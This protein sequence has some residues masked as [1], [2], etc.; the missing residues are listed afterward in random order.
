[1][2]IQTKDGILLRGIP[3]GTPDDE[4]KARIAK[5]RAERSVPPTEKFVPSGEKDP[6]IGEMIAGNPVTRFALGA[7]SPV[8]GAAQLGA[9]IQD[10]IY[11]LLGIPFQPGK[12]INEHLAQLERMKQGGRAITG[13]SGFDPVETAGAVVSPPFLA[14]AKAVQPAATLAGKVAQGTGFGVAGA[15]TAPVTGEG[16]YETQ[17]AVQTATGAAVG[18]ALPAALAAGGAVGKAGYRALIEPWMQPAAIK[19]RAFLEAAGDKADE[20]IALLRQ[21]REI[22]P[23]SRP[24][25]GEA[26]APAG[27]AE[28]AALQKSAEQAAPS[29]YLAR[30]D[31]QNAARL[32]AV[33]DVGKDKQ[34]LDTAIAVRSGK[35]QK[36]YGIVADDVVTPDQTFN[37]ILSRPSM[38]KAMDKAKALTAEQGGTW[39]EDLAQ[40]ATVRQ[41]QNVKMALDDMLKNPEQFGL[42]A[43]EA[44]AISATRIQFVQWLN[45][46]SPG[47]QYARDKFAAQSKPINQMEVGQELERRLVPALSEDAKQKASTYAAALQN[48]PQTIKKATGEPRYRDLSEVLTPD[49]LAKVNSVRDDLA[50]GARFEDMAKRGAGTPSAQEVATASMEGGTGGKLPNTLNPVVT[51]ANRIFSRLEGKI[52]KK[53][54]AE[55]AADML[56]PVKVGDSLAR[57]QMREKRNKMIAERIQG[58]INLGAAGSANQQ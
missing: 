40:G 55:I 28:F 50:R 4:I 22:V 16:D 10:P 58:Y 11:R 44:K 38:A 56:D 15:L 25:A 5:I 2:D 48:A 53:L 35:A 3:D 23:G 8:L 14:A 37:T 19:G 7:A 12:G 52:N 49:Q 31:E 13:D 41:M 54:A 20:I 26:A 29:K 43:S 34:A 18:A 47:W 36:N 6:P 27:R 17:K 9:N 57:A 1:M 45:K 42:G 51:W 30:A 39:P 24:T 33:R 46:E 32:A 21:N